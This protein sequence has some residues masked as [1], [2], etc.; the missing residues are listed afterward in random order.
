[1]FQ[2]LRAYNSVFSS[3]EIQNLIVLQVLY[4]NLSNF[5][6]KTLKINFLFQN[7]VDDENDGEL[8]PPPRRFSV[9]SIGR[10]GSI[11]SSLPTTSRVTPPILSRR[12]MATSP[13]PPS[14]PEVAFKI[15]TAC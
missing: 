5:K 13:E 1:M 7:E 10:R 11:V 14:S 4:L 6:F 2:G 3:S 12:S 8:R 15:E 9:V